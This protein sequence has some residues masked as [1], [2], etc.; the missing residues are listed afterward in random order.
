[1]KKNIMIRSEKQFVINRNKV[2]SPTSMYN[3]HYHHNLEVYYLYSGE[4]YYFIKDKTYHIKKGSLIFIS[5]MTIHSTINVK[6]IGYDRFV[7]NFDR[8]LLTDFI[9]LSNSSLFEYFDNDIH[10]INLNYNDQLFVEQLLIKMQEEN[11]SSKENYNLFIKTSIVQIL[12]TA[13]RYRK[14]ISAKEEKINVKKNSISEISAYINQNYHEDITLNTL[15]KKFYI[16]IYHLSRTFKNETGLSFVDYLNNVR[17][18]ESLTL[19]EQSDFNITQIS[20]KVG[21]K[22]ATHFGRIFKKITGI[23]PLAYKKSKKTDS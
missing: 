3:H 4:R 13:L 14:T 8:D 15:S 9:N 20:E 10:V 11:F 18:K 12:L 16:S 2:D 17:V 21:F 23:S 7:F 5:E 19:L 22:S 6:N 1:M